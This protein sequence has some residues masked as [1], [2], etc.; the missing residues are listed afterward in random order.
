MILKHSKFR[1]RIAVPLLAAVAFTVVAGTAYSLTTRASSGHDT[2][3]PQSHSLREDFTARLLALGQRDL[4]PAASSSFTTLAATVSGRSWSFSTYRNDA[5][6]VCIMEQHPG[7]A[8][9]YGC[10]SRHTLFAGGPLFAS[11]GSSQGSTASRDA[12]QWDV[13]WVEGITTPAV[14]AVDL[15]L[16][17]CN[18]LG[19]ALSPDRSF[20]AVVGPDYLHAGVLPHRLDAKNAAGKTIASRSINLGPPSSKTGNI[21]QPPAVAANGC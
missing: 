5:G 20:F 12:G 18:T 15:V 6:D 19:L 17:D 16:S 2:P 11:W 3:A 1:H 14:A 21:G 4:A 13:S 10:R 9:G 7:G 8:R